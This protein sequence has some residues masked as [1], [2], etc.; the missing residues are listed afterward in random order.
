VEP[1]VKKGRHRRYEEAR[2]LKRGPDLDIESILDDDGLGGPSRTSTDPEDF[3]VLEFDGPR[4][5]NG[6]DP[7]GTDTADGTDFD[8]TDSDGG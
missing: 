3:D 7:D 4:S 6:P 5:S 1:S 8:G 2:A